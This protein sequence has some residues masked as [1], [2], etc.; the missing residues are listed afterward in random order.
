[1][2]VSAIHRFRD[3]A[4]NDLTIRGQNAHELLSSL[5]KNILN[6]SYLGKWVPGLVIQQLG[7]DRML[8]AAAAAQQVAVGGEAPKKDLASDIAA[9]RTYDHPPVE[10]A[11]Q[12][13][14][15]INDLW[16][17]PEHMYQTGPNGEPWAML[18]SG[19]MVVDKNG[20][21]LIL[22]DE[23][24]VEVGRES[25]STATWKLPNDE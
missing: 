14:I 17:A 23:N 4:T 24:G 7:A 25:L 3:L 8:D 22:R 5:N 10:K 11:R 15:N 19:S 6:P 20:P 12:Y 2:T 16:T 18:A 13:S 9:S 21:M 1:E